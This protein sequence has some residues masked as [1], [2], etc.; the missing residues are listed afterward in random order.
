[1]FALRGH[2]RGEKDVLRTFQAA[3][4][5]YLRFLRAWLGD[6]RARVVGGKDS[7]GRSRSG[8]R[9]ILSNRRLTGQRGGTWSRRITHLFKGYVT[10]PRTLDGLMLRT[11]VGLRSKNKM[12]RAV[13]KL[14]E[15][16]TISG[17]GKQM[18]VPIYKNLNKIGV[19]EGFSN[20]KAF[21]R[22]AIKG[23]LAGVKDGGK[24][25]YFDV[26]ARKKRGKGYKRSGLLFV[27]VFGVKIKPMFTGRY[28]YI[29]RWDRML[30]AMLNRGQGAVDRA[31]NAVDRGVFR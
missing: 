3:P 19:T 29:A 4:L 26:N 2:I 1:M 31:T 18:P 17:G 8:F 6:E 24:V 25:L 11:G 28:D 9:D 16:G 7:K 5:T 20:A 23:R 13:Q 15:G 14:N 10:K 30:P 22:L 12:I 27:G 21:K